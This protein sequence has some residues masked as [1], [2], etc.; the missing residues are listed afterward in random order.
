VT[1]IDPTGRLLAGLREQAQTLRRQ[2]PSTPEWQNAQTAKSDDGSERLARNIAAI[3][4]DDPQRNRN[5]FRAYLQSVLLQEFGTTLANDPAFGALL[6]RIQDAMEADPALRQSM[7]QA[8]NLL[9]EKYK[10]AS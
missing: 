8:S 6:D 7:E 1:S 10:I 4:K 9:L 2:S 5:V 3:N